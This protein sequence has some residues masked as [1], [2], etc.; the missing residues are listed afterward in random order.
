M[1]LLAG[2]FLMLVLAVAGCDGDEPDDGP[3]AIASSTS[4]PTPQAAADKPTPAPTPPAGEVAVAN[5]AFSVETADGAVLHG[6]LYSPDGPQRQALVIVAPVD[7]ETWEESVEPF[8]D[9]G[10]AVFTFDPRGFGETGGPEKPDALADDAQLVTLFAAS[11]EYPLI[12]ILAAGAEASEAVLAK[13]AQREEL[14]GLATYGFGGEAG[15]TDHLALAPEA[16]WDGENVL[17]D[18]A[19]LEQVLAFVLGEN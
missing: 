14:T 16:T 7:Q 6:R 11:R 13:A 3:A 17:E 1:R 15:V 19:I 2:A 10:V 4:T 9:E 5:E 8:T 12:Y 18:A